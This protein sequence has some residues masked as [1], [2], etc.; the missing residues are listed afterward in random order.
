MLLRSGI[1]LCRW[2]R[3]ATLT[4]VIP[5]R[6]HKSPSKH[7]FKVLVRKNACLHLVHVSLHGY[8]ILL[9]KLVNTC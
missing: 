7:L 9:Y 5:P 3:K 8:L 1:I 6:M 4:G 2:N